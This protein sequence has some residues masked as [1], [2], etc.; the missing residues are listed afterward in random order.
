MS[1]SE[2]SSVVV[3]IDQGLPAGRRGGREPRQALVPRRKRHAAAQAPSGPLLHVRAAASPLEREFGIDAEEELA[4]ERQEPPPGVRAL[5]LERRLNQPGSVRRRGARLGRGQLRAPPD[6]HGS[7]LLLGAELH[8]VDVEAGR[9][10]P[11]RV[12]DHDVPGLQEAL[13]RAPRLRS[14][15]R[16]PRPEPARELIAQVV[17]ADDDRPRPRR[18]LDLRVI[19]LADGPAGVEDVPPGVGEQEERPVD[20]AVL[21]LRDPVGVVVG[22]DRQPERAAPPPLVPLAELGEQL[23]RLCGRHEL[24]PRLVLDLLLGV[25]V[26]AAH[27]AELV[28]PHLVALAEPELEDLQRR[29]APPLP[30]LQ[31]G[32]DERP[33]D[34]PQCRPRLVRESTQR[35]GELRRLLPRGEMAEDHVPASAWPPV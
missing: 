25:L 27:D 28:L 4:E 33:V 21:L 10:D 9:A 31:S 23:G 12:R 8:P 30:V 11:L 17:V 1:R 3:A 26:V 29:H 18:D 14:R 2:S 24:E 15:D 32:G 16:D 35:L 19:A 20:L 5:L 7:A 6:D 34:A 22:R 13:R